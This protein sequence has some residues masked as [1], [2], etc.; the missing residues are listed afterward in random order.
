MEPDDV[1]TIIPL[2][3]FFDDR[4][5]QVKVDALLARRPIVREVVAERLRFS[6]AP[7][8]VCRVCDTY[9]VIFNL[10]QSV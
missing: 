10:C 7:T 1:L 4:R 9:L 3:G 2:K 5:A 8:G 6:F